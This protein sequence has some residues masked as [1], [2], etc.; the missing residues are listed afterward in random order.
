MF[1][2]LSADPSLS[3][4]A[5]QDIAGLC[6]ITAEQIVPSVPAQASALRDCVVWFNRNFRFAADSGIGRLAADTVAGRPDSALTWLRAGSDPSVRWL[7]DDD[8]SPQPATLDVAADGYAPYQA[9][10][11]AALLAAP[12]NAGL[13]GA[14][15]AAACMDAF[16]R[17]RVLCAVREGPRGVSAINRWMSQQIIAALGLPAPEP[18]RAW[19]AGRPVMVLQ[20]DAALRLFNGDIGITLPDAQGSLAVYFP[21]ADGGFRAVA[22]LRLPPHQTAF[23]MT[24]HKSQG[25]EFDAVLVLLPAQRNRVLGRELLYTAITRARQRVVL[26]AGAP[27]LASA[28]Q[29]RSQR[30]S[31]LLSRLAQACGAPTG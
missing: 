15:H 18:G 6:G 19:F 23:A 9:A 3:L 21:A 17:F 30:R 14:P 22:P 26:A 8:T 5:R 24:V 25:S 31:G 7:A 29:A 1:A 2:D 27:V 28:I 4:D 10:L 16:N 20:N 12:T 13:A 11:Q